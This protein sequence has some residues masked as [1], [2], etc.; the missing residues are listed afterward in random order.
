MCRCLGQ[1]VACSVTWG[2]AGAS[3][4]EAENWVADEELK[5]WRPWESQLL[6]FPLSLLRKRAPLPGAAEPS[7]VP[8]PW[9][10]SAR[11]VGAVRLQSSPH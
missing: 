6:A 1:A 10:V 2:R 3:S 4:A 8:V 7:W 11:E 5:C 9:T